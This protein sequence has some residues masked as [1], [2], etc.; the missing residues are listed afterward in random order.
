MSFI[1]ESLINNFKNKSAEI[2][3]PRQPS[4]ATKYEITDALTSAFSIFFMQDSSFLS[5]QRRIAQNN[6]K[7]NFNTLFYGLD[8]PTDAQT[9]N[10]LDKIDY[11]YIND[12]F[13]DN[14]NFAREYGVLEKFAFLKDHNDRYSYGIAIDGTE[15]YRSQKIYCDNC[16]FCEKNGVKTYRHEALMIGIV[17]PDLNECLSLM[18]EFIANNDGNEKQDCEI[19][20]VKRAIEN[21]WEFYKTFNPTFLGDALYSKNSICKLIQE[22]GGYFIFVA[23]ES[24]NKTLFKNISL[25]KLQNYDRKYK[26][27]NKE[28]TENIKFV[29][30]VQ[31]TSAEDSVYI[32]YL[33]YTIFDKNGKKIYHNK[34]ITNHKITLLN[35]KNLVKLGRSRWKVENENNNTLKTKGYN[36]EHSYGHGEKFLAAML[37]TLAIL[38]FLTHTIM[39]L[40]YDWYVKASKICGT[41]INFF[42]Q[43]K[44]ITRFMLFENW[45]DLFKM[46]Y[47]PPEGIKY[48]DLCLKN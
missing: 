1:I 20:A 42:N 19:N 22:K 43:M 6:T 7:S 44:F 31:L 24:S 14:I 11:K 45:E 27:K 48:K 8:I 10:I 16:L 18:P 38:A 15:Y 29:N 12:I 13:I 21:N 47:D 3:D 23:K 34:F 25:S 9:R 28:Y 5:Y 46:L 40:S 35:A 2:P 39:S 30:N 32:N 4:N 17:R 36:F 26:E 33:E 41:R 37:A